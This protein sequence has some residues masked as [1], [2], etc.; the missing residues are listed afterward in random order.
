[1]DGVGKS[2]L[3][4]SLSEHFNFYAIR[5]SFYA[6]LKDLPIVD[7]YIRICNYVL[8]IDSE[9]Y[10]QCLVQ[11]RS[12][13][14]YYRLKGLSIVLDR[15]YAA[16]VKYLLRDDVNIQELVMLFGIPEYT[17]LLTAS[18][19]KLMERL[20]ARD[21]SDKDI[22]KLQLTDSVYLAIKRNF[23][24]F[25]IPYYEIDT[26]NKSLEEVYNEAINHIKHS[27]VSRAK[28]KS[29]ICAFS[30]PFSDTKTFSVSD[31]TVDI[32]PNAFYY[33]NLLEEIMVPRSNPYYFAQD[34]VLFSK[35][36]QTL[37]YYPCN[38]NNDRYTVP[39]HI[40]F[41]KPSAFMNA[42]N[43]V[44]ITLPEGL[45]EIGSN[46]FFNCQK[47][48]TITIPSKVRRIGY[49]N[50][51]GCDS[52]D[53]INV[54]KDNLFYSSIDGVLFDKQKQHLLSYPIGKIPLT[55]TVSC[56][57]VSEWSFAE[58][59]YLK[60]IILSDEVISI[61]AYAFI[62]SSIEEIVIRSTSLHHI[63]EGAFKGCTK[64]QSIV[65]PQTLSHLFD[66]RCFIGLSQS[67]LLTFLP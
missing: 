39:E 59:M 29:R 55:Y 41:L 27:D 2:S 61:G 65:V 31:D 20:V 34:G 63:G 62:N 50:F 12:I 9:K 57:F 18:K 40:Q 53:A 25:D 44:E 48:K 11:C 13:F 66:D 52:L 4:R 46:A 54:S 5:Q 60:R 15:F 28:F 10:T 21:P 43:L 58:N 1:M 24:A 14:I 32:S 6:I 67:V 51:I 23:S 42:K 56:P 36:R 16:H 30:L 47:V 26:D 7:N 33:L 37:A 38:R 45:I 17:I 3:A 22:P 49:F 35:D 64:L 19:E 8:S